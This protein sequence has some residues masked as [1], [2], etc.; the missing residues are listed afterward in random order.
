MIDALVDYYERYNANIHRGVHSW[1]RRPRP[2]TR[3]AREGRPASSTPAPPEE[4][5]F[6]RNTTEAINLVAYAWGRKCSG[7]A[8]RS[9]VTEMEHHSNLDPVAD[10]RAEHRAPCCG[11]VRCRRRRHARSASSTRRCSPTGRRLVAVTQMSNVLGTINPVREIAA[12]AHARGALILVDGAQ[13]V[14]HL[15]V[16]VQRPGLR[17]PG[18]LGAQDAGADGRRRALAASAPSSTRCA[19][20][21]AAAT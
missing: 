15:P 21:W 11:I 10:D 8:T 4:I 14:P 6:T 17:L 12:L 19:R 13:S 5:I 9:C 18:L 2:P 1:P 16:D 7:R 20:S 3:R